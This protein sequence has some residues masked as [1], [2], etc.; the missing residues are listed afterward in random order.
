MTPT[1]Y[2][3]T[4]RTASFMRAGSLVVKMVSVQRRKAS[5]SAGGMPS[6]LHVT[7]IDIGKDTLRSRS[8]SCSPASVSSRP[9]TI[10]V[11]SGRSDSTLL[12]VNAFADSSRSRV[13]SGGSAKSMCLVRMS[14]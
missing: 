3:S 9:S 7:A 2:S 13:W 1:R 10:R 4:A 12:R 8:I 5:S 14:V 11:I 6:N